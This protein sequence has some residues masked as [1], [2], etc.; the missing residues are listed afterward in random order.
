MSTFVSRVLTAGGTSSSQLIAG[1][2]ATARNREATVGAG[3]GPAIRTCDRW[4]RSAAPAAGPDRG[5]GPGNARPSG[6]FRAPS[7][8]SSPLE[9]A[10]IPGASRAANR[11][12][13]HGAVVIPGEA[14]DG[15]AAA[16]R[17]V[18]DAELYVLEP[19]R[20]AIAE[21]VRPQVA[22]LRRWRSE[23]AAHRRIS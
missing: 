14:A 1:P 11:S 2:A 19:C 22:D 13:L 12:P 6:F 7:G 18:A 20:R 10:V 9:G 21:G 17:S 4:Y 3:N 5:A 15:L 16:C 8:P 23:M